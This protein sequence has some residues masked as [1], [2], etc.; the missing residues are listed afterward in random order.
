MSNERMMLG[1]LNHAENATVASATPAQT[2][3][4]VSNAV[5]RRIARTFKAQ[6]SARRQMSITLDL[7]ATY[8]Q[9]LAR[10][11]TLTRHVL[12]T[13]GRFRIQAGNVADLGE[14]DALF[15]LLA[16]ELDP[17]ITFTRASA[18]AYVDADGLIQFADSN[19]WP[20]DHYPINGRRRGRFPE[21]A[22]TN[23]R[24]RS[25]AFTN[26]VYTESGA[27]SLDNLA[28]SP[29][30]TLTA[31]LLLEDGSDGGH[32]QTD[33]VTISADT[34]YAVSRWFRAAG[35]TRIEMTWG[36]ATGTDT[37]SAVFD[38]RTG[39]KPTA[40]A[41]GSAS[42]ADAFV[43][44]ARNGWV[45]CTVVGKINASATT[46]RTTVSLYDGSSTSYVGVLGR[47]VA[48]WNAQVEAGAS[49]SSDIPTEGSTVTRAADV[50]TVE[51]EDFTSWFV[52][53][54]GALL[55][56]YEA[57]VDVDQAV[58]L[59]I[60]GLSDGT[61]SNYMARISV[62]PTANTHQAM[63]AHAGAVQSQRQTSTYLNGDCRVATAWAANDF[64]ASFNGQTT[65]TGSSG[66]LATVDR[67]NIGT[68]PTGTTQPNTHIQEIAYFSRRTPNAQLE[69]WSRRGAVIDTDFAACSVDLPVEYTFT[70][71]S[72]G[73]YTDSLGRTQGLYTAVTAPIVPQTTREER[74]RNGGFDA[75]SLWTKGTGWAIAS[76]VATKTAGSASNLTQTIPTIPG[77]VYRLRATVTRSA[78]SVVVDAGGTDLVT[79]SAAG[80]VSET[81]TASATTTVIGFEADSTFAGTIDNVS[82]TLDTGLRIPVG[83]GLDLRPGQCLRIEPTD[84]TA[85]TYMIGDVVAYEGAI[86][87]VDV[88]EAAAPELVSNGHFTSATTGWT[89]SNGSTLAVSSGEMEVS[90]PGA[91]AGP[92]ATQALTTTSGATYIVTAS[93]RRGTSS[94]NCTVQL[95]GT[96]ASTTLQATTSTVSAP[97]VFTFTA[98]STSSSL[99]ALY[100]GGTPAAAETAYFDNISVKRAHT[101]WDVELVG[102]RLTHD[103][104][105]T[106]LGLLLES[107]DTCTVEGT[108]FT[109]RWRADAA[110]ALIAGTAPASLSGTHTL[111]SVDDGTADERVELVAVD[112]A[113]SLLVVDGGSTVASLALGS[114][115]AGA[116]FRVAVAIKANDVAGSLD[117]AAVVTDTSA[118]LPTVTTMRLGLDYAGGDAWGG[119]VSRTIL[120]A[121]RV[122]DADLVA[123]ATSGADL[124]AYTIPGTLADAYAGTYDSDWTK[125]WDGGHSASDI[126]SQEPTLRKILSADVAYRYWRLDLYDHPGPDADPAGEDDA[127]TLEAGY[128][129][130]W[131]VWQPAYNP[132]PGAGDQLDDPSIVIASW[133]GSE[134]IDARALQR[135]QTLGWPLLGEADARTFRRIEEHA[136]I[137]APMYFLWRPDDTDD[138]ILDDMLCRFERLSQIQKLVAV[139]FAFA[140]RLKRWTGGP[141]SA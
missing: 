78:G 69:A 41:A 139:R 59:Y 98:G 63:W 18:K 28:T 140:C 104:E 19:V 3:R 77:Q 74:V 87:T 124:D 88:I 23:L 141:P 118:S 35:R 71:A 123:M 48:M 22:R 36:D 61:F 9:N 2:D 129:G 102:P 101:A 5:N 80:A 33:D 106:P 82:V 65:L 116:A 133:A 96:G 62:S 92:G 13:R 132:E 128:L 64:A 7:G 43:T 91:T 131:R 117:G 68:S 60:A 24:T 107:A 4:G 46:G 70:R 25:C 103:A 54:P 113:L 20:L 125:A 44:R 38:L 6:A 58:V 138:W 10:V 37:I 135:V 42:S 99:I 127:V 73:S 12:G 137:S 55:V 84:G 17:R 52:Q 53:G 95:S 8:S 100:Q 1:W 94:T 115:T 108:A 130:L 85:N 56:R 14:P 122:A 97:I 114:L 119:T 21:G 110:S 134:D 105:S 30:G 45:R 49:P 72:G 50:A 111:W 57:P 109:A 90:A 11:L 76:G 29:A 34:V 39:V 40:S 51:G 26:A 16:D 66:S 31:G 86:V 89:A 27:T 47:G 79:V 126:G 93:A 67:L 81:F 75:D 136:R 112:G 83:A 15:D 120:W 32:T 121:E